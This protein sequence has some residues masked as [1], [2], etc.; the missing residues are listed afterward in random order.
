MQPITE[1]LRTIV[2]TAIDRGESQMSIARKAGITRS[3]LCKWLNGRASITIET[4]DKIAA[5]CM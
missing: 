4:A 5:A 2:E 1:H 3:Q